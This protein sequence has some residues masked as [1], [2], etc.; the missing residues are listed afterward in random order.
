MSYN[1]AQI[2]H[3]Q[4]QCFMSKINFIFIYF[5]FIY[6]FIFFLFKMIAVSIWIEG[7]KRIPVWKPRK[8]DVGSLKAASKI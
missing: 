5:I 3:N 6:L 1:A 7:V 4:K 2:Q 8:K